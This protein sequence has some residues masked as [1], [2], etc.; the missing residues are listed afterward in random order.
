MWIVL[1]EWKNSVHSY[2]FLACISSFVSN[3]GYLFEMKATTEEA[4][5]TALKLS[6]AGR[7]WITFA[8]FLFAAKMCRVR[9][10][11]WLIG[12]L[13]VIHTGIYAA[14]LTI[15]SN[16]LY[17][18]TYQFVSDPIFPRFYHD[19]GIVHDL[20]MSFNI[21]FAVLAM[22][23]LVAEYR[24]ERAKKAQY[25]FLMLI[26]S[27]GVQMIAFLLQITGVFGISMYYDLT[28]PATLFDLM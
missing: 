9:L 17:Y 5:L 27:F 23:W 20:L 15:G 7:V 13:T 26:M 4:Y 11:K 16:T 8:L 1:I 24:R 6:Y 25:R 22:W 21:V 28:M 14:V 12:V 3:M 10:P 2:L 18:P 19:N